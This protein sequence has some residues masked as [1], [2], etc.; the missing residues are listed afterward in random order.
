MTFYLSDELP[1]KWNNEDV[2]ELISKR[3]RLQK[4]AKN[5]YKNTG[6][7]EKGHDEQTRPKLRFFSLGEHE[8]VITLTNVAGI[9]LTQFGH[10]SEEGPN[11]E[12]LFDLCT[13]TFFFSFYYIMA[14]GNVGT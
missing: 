10:K 6:R 14:I 4:A 7:A 2:Y 3:D 8:R 9:K 12:Y 1:I 13:T 5:E 11:L